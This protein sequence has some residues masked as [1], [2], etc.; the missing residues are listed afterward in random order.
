[1]MHCQ[2]CDMMEWVANTPETAPAFVLANAGYD[3]WMGNNRGSRYSLSHKTKKPTDLDFWDFYQEDMGMYDLPTLVTFIKGKTGHE[4]ISYVGHSEGTT[5]ILMGGSLNPNFFRNHINLAV[6]TGP[7]ACTANI[8]SKPI[9]LAAHHIKEIQFLLVHVLKMYNTWGPMP[10]A[11][12]ALET[13]CHFFPDL[14]KTVI[15]FLHHEGVDN[16]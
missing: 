2:D 7:V 3:V 15:G 8:P 4:S 6:L 14:C 13:F 16:A 12:E 9:R 5:Q 11:V 1:M 10:V